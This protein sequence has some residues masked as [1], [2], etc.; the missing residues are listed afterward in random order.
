MIEEV[1]LQL[2]FGI[3]ARDDRI[4]AI[5]ERHDFA[6]EAV[7]QG[8][9]VSGMLMVLIL[10]VERGGSQAHG[11]SECEGGNS[12]EQRAFLKRQNIVTFPF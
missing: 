9:R 12:G 11:Q 4:V 3:A 5:L 7:R 10:R 8:M 2:A 6:G 1:A